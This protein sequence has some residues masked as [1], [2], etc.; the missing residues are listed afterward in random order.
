MCYPLELWEGIF[1]GNCYLETANL[2]HMGLGLPTSLMSKVTSRATHL[3]ELLM[4][5]WS[6]LRF[7][8]IAR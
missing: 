4:S 8:L 5:P 2:R 7:T 6:S 3:P 1:C